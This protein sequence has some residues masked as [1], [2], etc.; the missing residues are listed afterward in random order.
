MNILLITNMYP[1]FSNQSKIKATYAVHYFAKEWAKNHNV[2]VIRLW[3]TYPKIFTVLKRCRTVNK[4]GFQDNYILDG[5]DIT[6]MPILKIPKINYRDKDIRTVANKIIKMIVNETKDNNFPDVVICDILNPFIYIG[7]IVAEKFNSK[8]VAS[9]HNSDISYLYRPKNYKQFMTTDSNIDKIVFRSDKVEKIFLQLYNGNE[10]KNRYSKIL[11]GIQKTDIIAQKVLNEKLSKPN[12]VILIAASLKKLK[13]VD[14]LIKAFSKIKNNNGY[15]L[16]IVG[17]GP[18]RKTLEE[19]V[20]SLDCGKD[21]I[22]EG[23]KNREEVLSFMEKSEIFAMVS[24]PETFGLVYIEAMAKAC[25]TIGS[26][27]EGID[28]VIINEENGFL[29]IPNSVEDLRVN[30][31][32]TMNL[33]KEEKSGIINNALNTV[34]D[35]TYERLASKFL[36]EIEK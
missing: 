27:G 28:G 1:A 12:K 24:S 18:E 15:I 30:L 9:L 8:L 13:K 2:K 16:K 29:C 11:F 35:L 5:V 21:V 31:E 3:S 20:V 19:L 22:F 6:R 14:V 32:K 17:D 26:K 7:A 4:Y 10:K 33:N 25:I 36:I 23:E 34:E